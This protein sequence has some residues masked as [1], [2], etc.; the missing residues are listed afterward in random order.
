MINDAGRKVG[1][2]N[3]R[4]FI[5]PAE[6]TLRTAF[7]SFKAAGVSDVIVDLRYNG[8]GLLSTAQVLANLLGGNRSTSDV[9]DY[10]TFRPEKSANNTVANFAPEA[11]SVA[12]AHIAFIGAGGTAS[13]FY[14]VMN[15]FTP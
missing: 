11:S 15:A 12:P 4:T 10:Q 8:G 13:S 14:L 6:G 1:Y 2:L 3:L 5:T 7:A 9:I